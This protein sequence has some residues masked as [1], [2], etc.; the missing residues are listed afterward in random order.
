MARLVKQEPEG[1]KFILCYMT[2]PLI[3]KKKMDRSASQGVE[4]EETGDPLADL[5]FLSQQF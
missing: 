3:K 4:V 5:C 1:S 2:I